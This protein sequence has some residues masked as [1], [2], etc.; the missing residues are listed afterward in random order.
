MK[1]R[2]EWTRGAEGTR[3][4][5]GGACTAEGSGGGVAKAQEP[6]VTTAARRVQSGPGKRRRRRLEQRRGRGCHGAATTAARGVPYAALGTCPEY[7]WTS[8]PL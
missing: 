3:A 1:V 2:K 5:T 6:G 7:N 8:D 4:G